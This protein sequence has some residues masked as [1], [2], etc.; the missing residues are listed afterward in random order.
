MLAAG[1][2]ELER[3]EEEALQPNTLTF[4]LWKM[5]PTRWRLHRRAAASYSLAQLMEA[6]ENRGEDEE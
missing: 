3:A 4:H 1:D 6:T 5:I 2:G